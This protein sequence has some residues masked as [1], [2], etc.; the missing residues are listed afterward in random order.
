MLRQQT[1]HDAHFLSTRDV[2]THPST[3][4]ETLHAIP[5]SKL[6]KP[7]KDR[8]EEGNSGNARHH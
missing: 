1:V 4:M 2:A 3:H 5:F 8:E 7:V 6:P